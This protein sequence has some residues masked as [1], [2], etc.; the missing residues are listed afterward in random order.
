MLQFV[1]K[2][3]QGG[4][5]VMITVPS[6]TDSDKQRYKL[7]VKHFQRAEGILPVPPGAILKSVEARILQ[8]GVVRVRQTVN[9]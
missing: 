1:L 5:D 2:V 7:E 9:L 8:D 3:Q 6:E 4:K